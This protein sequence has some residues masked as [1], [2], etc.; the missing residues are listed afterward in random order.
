MDMR[1]EI[2]RKAYEIYERNGRSEGRDM[3]NWLEAERI[4]M[5]MM[6]SGIDSNAPEQRGSD[7]AALLKQAGMKKTAKAKG[8]TK[9]MEV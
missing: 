3:D 4:V 9:R 5:S 8:R 2:A 1:K 6:K 7:H